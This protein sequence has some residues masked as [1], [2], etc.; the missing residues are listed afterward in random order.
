MLFNKDIYI[1]SFLNFAKNI[2]IFIY[3]FIFAELTS[4]TINSATSYDSYGVLKYSL[5]FFLILFISK[6]IDLFLGIYTEKRLVKSKQSFKE[7]LYEFM[8]KQR[9]YIIESLG[10]GGVKER[11]NDDTNIAFIFLTKN[12]PSIITGFF[13]AFGYALYISRINLY[14]G[15]FLVLI[16]FLQLI[17]PFVV[18]RWL[19]ENYEDTRDIESELT[20]H[21]L[22]GYNGLSTI[23]QFNAE[24]FYMKKLAKLH[25]DYYKIGKKSEV[26]AQFETAL[27]NAISSI[28]TYVTYCIIGLFLFKGSI[29]L[30]FAVATI[31]LVKGFY[32]GVGSIFSGLPKYFLFSKAMERLKDL[33]PKD[34]KILYH[35]FHHELPLFQLN[36][37]SYGYDDKILMKDLN[38]SLYANYKYAV[39]GDNGCGK[40]TLIKILSGLNRSYMGEVL[41]RGCDIKNLNDFELFSIVEYLPQ[42]DPIIDLTPKSL[43]M[44]ICEGDDITLNKILSTASILGLDKNILNEQ[45]ISELS[46]GQRKK[47][48]LSVA[49][50][51]KR[52]VLILDEPTNT[53]D[54][55]SQKRLLSMIKNSN[56]S[57]IMITHNRE[58]MNCCDFVL[59]VS[60]GGVIV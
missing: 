43:Y 35:S 23:K 19:I 55:D 39:V 25:K 12:I 15:L 2:W 44:M 14:L 45:N 30:E 36:S 34:E 3:T 57:I 60:K 50:C 6:I 47:V 8:F 26:T 52:E 58:F 7:S 9:V 1:T 41:Y 21:I 40:S 4:K 53:L 31:V 56:K 13:V 22:E 32:Q 27:D 33:I 51:S 49:L 11:L 38:A 42:E 16:S 10:L 20:E 59:N 54:L 48:F 17:P 5:I 29:T 28:L 18:K 46:G 37:L 24:G